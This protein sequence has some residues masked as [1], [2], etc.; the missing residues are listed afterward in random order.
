MGIGF[1][2]SSS[3]SLF[4]GDRFHRGR[5]R[6]AANGQGRGNV[7]YL[8]TASQQPWGCLQ[9]R[10]GSNQYHRRQRG[11]GRAVRASETLFMKAGVF[12]ECSLRWCEVVVCGCS[13]LSRG[14]VA[15]LRRSRSGKTLRGRYSNI[16]WS[17]PA[18]H[19]TSLRSYATLHDPFS[20]S[21]RVAHSDVAF[22]V[23]GDEIGFHK[24]ASLFPTCLR[25]SSSSPRAAHQP[26][27][28]LAAAAAPAA[29]PVQ[30]DDRYL[31]NFP[32]VADAQTSC[33]RVGLSW[34]VTSSDGPH[35]MSQTPSP[36][37]PACWAE[38]SPIRGRR[39]RRCLVPG[40]AFWPRARMS[41][42][43]STLAEF[44]NQP[45]YLS[46]LL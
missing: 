16:P 26:T 33:H 12:G 40:Q 35:S 11:R 30:R 2:D 28:H 9:L 34:A 31:P 39:G 24:P 4:L 41:T 1:A 46:R 3:V 29:P 5:G 23:G 21:F 25:T 15:K 44:Q 19:L 27:L 32:T 22:P 43:T 42:H 13:C 45:A 36:G 7:V 14:K 20:D 17:S 6:T 10:T 37:A 38:T 8:Q 18:L